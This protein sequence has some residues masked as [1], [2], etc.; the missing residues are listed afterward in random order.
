MYP[1]NIETSNMRAFNPE[2]TL[3]AGETLHRSGFVEEYGY[4]IYEDG[5]NRKLYLILEKPAQQFFTSQ[6]LTGAVTHCQILYDRSSGH[7]YSRGTPENDVGGSFRLDD[8]Q[9]ELAVL[10]SLCDISDRD[11]HTRQNYTIWQGLVY[12]FDIPFDARFLLDT[13]GKEQIRKVHARFDTLSHVQ[14]M[15][16]KK[17]IDALIIRFGGE[18]G[19]TLM[20]RMMK[21]ARSCADNSRKHTHNDYTSVAQ[22]T[23]PHTKY[24]SMVQRSEID[25]DLD[26]GGITFDQFYNIFARRLHYL[27][28]L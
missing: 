13:T 17:K 4:P 23:P 9:A 10:S 8:A 24:E 14:K 22:N 2:R 7:F 6:L 11:V 28:T 27:A 5:T 19:K 15:L 25:L 20:R 16:F 12:N 18:Y 26:F 1:E 3:L 21:H